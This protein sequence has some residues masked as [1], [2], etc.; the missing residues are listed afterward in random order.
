[1]NMQQSQQVLSNHQGG[2]LSAS[3]R[4]ESAMLTQNHIVEASNEIHEQ[5]SQEESYELSPV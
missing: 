3:Q 4:L 5:D 1:M 2:A